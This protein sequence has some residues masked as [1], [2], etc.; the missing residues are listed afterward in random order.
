MI[1]NSRP[2]GTPSCTITRGFARA[3]AFSLIELLV[4]IAVI[5]LLIGLLLPGLGAARLAGRTTACGSRLQQMGAATTIYIDDHRG[6]LPQRSGPLP[7]GGED[8]IGALFAGKAGRLP[9]YGIDTI[10]AASRPLNPY[11]SERLPPEDVAGSPTPFPACSSP[12]D[13]GATTT[14]LPIPGLD[15]TASMYDFIGASYTLNDHSP[16]GEEF[17]TLVPRGGGRM[18]ALLRH[19]S[20]TWMIGTHPIYNYDG[21]GDRGMRWF[22]QQR[23]ETN[24]L[25]LDMHVR[26]RVP[27]APGQTEETPDYS[28]LP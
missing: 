28:F 4:V 12:V 20:R 9:F 24:L 22:G 11:L 1:S 5:A 8:I 18:P 19:P 25:F 16:R 27:V 7:Q 14:G 6:A 2:A 23:V 26:M 21:G 15:S 10:G 3:G 17:A 13:R